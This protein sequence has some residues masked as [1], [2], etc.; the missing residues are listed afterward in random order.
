M[1]DR[2]VFERVYRRRAAR[3][4]A[5]AEMDIDFDRTRFV[6][7]ETSEW[8]R[9]RTEDP[10]PRFIIERTVE[11]ALDHELQI[12]QAF[13]TLG[14]GRVLDL[15]ADFFP[16]LVVQFYANIE[17][18]QNMLTREIR[19]FVKNVHLHITE[20][21]IS[22]LL[23]VPSVGEYF[24]AGHDMIHSDRG[25]SASDAMT[26]HGVIP[27]ERHR[28][29]GVDHELLARGMPVRPRVLLHLISTNIFPRASNTQIVRLSNLYVVDRMIG[30]L[31]PTC[32]GIPLAAII[33]D[34]IR[35][36]AQ[37]NSTGKRFCFPILISLLLRRLGVDPSGER[38]QSPTSADRVDE[39]SMR[40]LRFS[41]R[42]GLTWVNPHMA[43]LQTSMPSS[44][45]PVPPVPPTSA[46]PPPSSSTG[47][48]PDIASILGRLASDIHQI[49]ESQSLML[50]MFMGTPRRS[51]EAGPSR[52]PPRFHE[53][54]EDDS[55][56]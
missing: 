56:D 26:R 1:A 16:E 46:P 30:G 9:A 4:Q 38:T 14:W 3:G 41:R 47:P 40:G 52:P 42:G 25:W 23:G 10:Y 20:A 12:R 7:R 35:Q 34:E 44:S 13:D 28:A 53:D 21:T 33:I 2:R 22:E 43:P 55:D 39:V 29:R 49:Q 27:R 51:H 54:D 37:F 8:Y 15:G 50:S 31:P 18:R 5:I 36:V 17:D 45:A 6:S 32:S 24:R 11:P 19:T 48:D